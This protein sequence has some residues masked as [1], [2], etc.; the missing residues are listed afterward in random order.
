MAMTTATRYS[1]H[2]LFFRLLTYSEYFIILYLNHN[3][4][5]IIKIMKDDRIT[6]NDH[7]HSHMGPVYERS[8]MYQRAPKVVL[9]KAE[10]HFPCWEFE[11][12]KAYLRNNLLRVLHLRQFR[13]CPFR[14]S[15]EM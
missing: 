13:H 15:T 1:V 3:E 9:S 10:N 6:A 11:L 12:P 14:K 8:E 2:G 5:E 4:N 7:H